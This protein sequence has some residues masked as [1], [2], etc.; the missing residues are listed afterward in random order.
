M[1]DEFIRHLVESGFEVPD[2]SP[3]ELAALTAAEEEALGS[4]WWVSP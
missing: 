1:P 2:L 4:D 3:R